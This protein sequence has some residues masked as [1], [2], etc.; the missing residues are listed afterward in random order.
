MNAPKCECEFKIDLYI[1]Y[2]SHH[3]LRIMCGFFSIPLNMQGCETGSTVYPSYPGRLESLA[4]ASRLQMSL[5]K[6]HGLLSYFKTLSVGL[7]RA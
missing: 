6:Q 4:V 7:T 2:Y 3:I 5:Q 1:G